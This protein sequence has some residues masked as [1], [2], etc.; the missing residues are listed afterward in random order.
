VGGG[1]TCVQR[2]G[3]VELNLDTDTS[4]DRVAALAWPDEVLDGPQPGET[5]G[6]PVQQLRTVPP[7]MGRRVH[8]VAKSILRPFPWFWSDLLV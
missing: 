1:V 4:R 7:I 5:S 3:D 2:K 6:S 8:G